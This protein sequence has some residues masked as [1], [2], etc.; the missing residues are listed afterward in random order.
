MVTA[1][2]LSK[3]RRGGWALSLS[4]VVAVLIIIINCHPL[5]EATPH[6]E[7]PQHPV[8]TTATSS[9]S[10]AAPR[11][12][13]PPSASTPQWRPPDSSPPAIPT[14]LRRYDT[15]ATP[16]ELLNIL[17]TST[18]PRTAVV[19]EP[20]D[21]GCITQLRPALQIACR[22][23][24]LHHEALWRTSWCPHLARCVM[25]G[26]GLFYPPLSQE[27]LVVS[28]K[29]A[30]ATL[31]HARLGLLISSA[32]EL[33]AY[34][35]N[36]EER[37]VYTRNDMMQQELCLSALSE[38]PTST[39]DRQEKQCRHHEITIPAH[40][41]FPSCRSMMGSDVCR[42]DKHPVVSREIGAPHVLDGISVL[43]ILFRMAS[44]ASA[45]T[46]DGRAVLV[47]SG[48]STLRETFLRLI[49][50]IRHKVAPDQNSSRPFF[51]LP[52]WS[53]ILYD[54][55]SDGD[56]IQLF[57]S[58]FSGGSRKHTSGILRVLQ[59]RHRHH[60]SEVKHDRP[61]PLVT[62][63]FLFSK[64]TAEPRR[65]LWHAQQEQRLESFVPLGLLV[66]GTLFWETERDPNFV[67]SWKQEA[68]RQRTSGSHPTF[69]FVAMMA[70]PKMELCRA[71]HCASVPQRKLTSSHQA[72][73]PIPLTKDVTTRS[74]SDVFNAQKN[75]EALQFMKHVVN[76][77]LSLAGRSYMW[78]R[79][80]VLDKAA[81]LWIPGILPIDH[82]HL[83]CR[84]LPTPDKPQD[85]LIRKGIHP[86]DQWH[87]I[88]SRGVSG[89]GSVKI[90]TMAL[91]EWAE[92]IHALEAAA[93]KQHFPPIHTPLRERWRHAGGKKRSIGHYVALAVDGRGCADV[94]NELLLYELLAGFVQM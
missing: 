94:G 3:Q 54:V 86:W 55:F 60:R 40:V 17:R 68:S 82:I 1:T 56:R 22:H 77:R 8:A 32:P 25:W 34:L 65:E 66:E 47:F 5:R 6:E 81:L 16:S 30:V 71:G 14:W 11:V 88:M 59:D 33:T 84:M 79:V 12:T 45:P 31:P 67:A 91:K 76:E 18:P 7:T 70:H 10:V 92:L 89:E 87:Y 26:E 48:D 53:D 75:A 62:M 46:S 58:P 73:Q 64:R 41:A 36:I 57:A 13:A 43:S 15:A 61:T 29:K 49:N 28:Y 78:E 50:L 27:M 83:S 19:I 38:S 4:C 2:A 63:L 52:T 72:P 35:K 74:T 21:E 93:T 39:T 20:G 44:I 9:S 80:A 37:A 90:S 69:P 23:L 42:V 51:D 85:P 24:E